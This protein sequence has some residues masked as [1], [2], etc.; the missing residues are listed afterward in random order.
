MIPRISTYLFLASISISSIGL[1]ACPLCSPNIAH[2]AHIFFLSSIHAISRFFLC[3][4]HTFNYSAFSCFPWLSCKANTWN[5]KC[6]GCG[7]WE[8]W[9]TSL[10]CHLGRCHQQYPLCKIWNICVTKPYSSAPRSSGKPLICSWEYQECYHLQDMWSC[11]FHL[12][13]WSWLS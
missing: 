11:T 3:N 6:C 1:K 12:S 9:E 7:R 4:R 13:F 2:P 8:I 10:Q 5:W